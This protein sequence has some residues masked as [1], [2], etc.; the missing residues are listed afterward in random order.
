SPRSEDSWRVLFW[1]R[2]IVWRRSIGEKSAGRK[3]FVLRSSTIY[4][5]GKNLWAWIC[6]DRLPVKS[7]NENLRV[8]GHPE[9]LAPFI[10]CRTPDTTEQIARYLLRSA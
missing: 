6:T 10:F 1:N 3:F 2:P 9:G 4:E 8:S 7:E 5:S